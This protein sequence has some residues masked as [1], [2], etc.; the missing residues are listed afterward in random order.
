MAA[1]RSKAASERF[2][3]EPGRFALQSICAFATLGK[4]ASNVAVVRFMLHIYAAL[5]EKERMISARTK[6]AFRAAKA[7]RHLG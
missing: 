1:S 6:A 4:F 2:N 3:H 7:R 5:A